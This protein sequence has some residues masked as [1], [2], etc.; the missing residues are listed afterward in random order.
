MTKYQEAVELWRLTY[1]HEKFNRRDRK[2]ESI[3]SKVKKGG[4]KLLP[5]MAFEEIARVEW[6]LSDPPFPW[7]RRE[8]ACRVFYGRLR[9][10]IRGRRRRGTL[11][12]EV[13][14]L[15]CR[16]AWE[17]LHSGKTAPAGT[18]EYDQF[19][20]RWWRERQGVDSPW[21]V[22]NRQSQKRHKRSKLLQYNQY[23]EGGGRLPQAAFLYPE[24]VFKSSKV[25]LGRLVNGC[26][27]CGCVDLACLEFHHQDPRMKEGMVGRFLLRS[28]LRPLEKELSKCVVLCCNCHRRRHLAASSRSARLLAAQES[29][30]PEEFVKRW[31][32]LLSQ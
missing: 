28:D 2:F 11:S 21:R 1:P 32:D 31:E 16:Q 20:A 17:A 5:R 24:Q 27:D 23:K 30:S 10:Q 26:V 8:R 4:P 19:Y 9:D 14:G 18:R 13:L 6:A 22:K 3:Y 7:S 15:P 25:L 12:R 29:S